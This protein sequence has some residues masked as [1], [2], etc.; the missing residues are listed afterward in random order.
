[1]LL[2]APAEVTGIAEVSSAL[3][4]ILSCEPRP[5]TGSGFYDHIL[6]SYPRTIH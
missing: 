6:Q 5:R 1:M 2:L 4:P 3:K